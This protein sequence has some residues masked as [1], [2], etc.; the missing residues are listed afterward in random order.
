[1]KKHIISIAL[2]IGVVVTLATSAYGR[3]DARVTEK[4]YSTAYQGSTL[5]SQSYCKV[6]GSDYTQIYIGNG[7]T[8]IKSS[9]GSVLSTGGT[10]GLFNPA[11]KFIASGWVSNRSSFTADYQVMLAYLWGNSSWKTQATW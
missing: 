2:A 9:T 10:V 3:T 5:C 7:R 8:R 6:V 1:M 4:G 11:E